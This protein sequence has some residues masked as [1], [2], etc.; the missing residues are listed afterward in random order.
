MEKLIKIL[1][2]QL[3]N[4]YVVDGC[5]FNVPGIS[6]LCDKGN[7]VNSNSTQCGV[8]NLETVKTCLS[9]SRVGNVCDNNIDAIDFKHIVSQLPMMMNG[10]GID[11]WS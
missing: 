5:K 8:L 2:T 1:L 4:V 3:R 9:R 10:C 7:K 11:Y 6:Q